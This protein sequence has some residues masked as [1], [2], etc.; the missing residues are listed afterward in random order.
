[1]HG[2]HLLSEVTEGRTLT[3]DYRLSRHEAGFFLYLKRFDRRPSA[4][5]RGFVNGLRGCS[6]SGSYPARGAHC[7]VWNQ[8]LVGSHTL[9]NKDLQQPVVLGKQKLRPE[10]RLVTRMRWV[11]RDDRVGH[12]ILPCRLPAS[13][14][15]IRIF[16]C[17]RG[18]WPRFD[19]PSP[20]PSSD[21]T[22]PARLAPRTDS[23]GNS[24]THVLF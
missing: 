1:M 9:L 6:T 17:D 2:P 10:A 21:R 12:P 3:A 22:L 8:S 23:S 14:D 19:P 4:F 20:V 13:R 15:R 16:L 11:V 18:K 5:V 7:T 24:R